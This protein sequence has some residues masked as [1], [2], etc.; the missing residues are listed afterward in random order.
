MKSAKAARAKIVEA[1][2]RAAN[3]ERELCEAIAHASK[4][5]QEFQKQK[6]HANALSRNALC[7]IIRIGEASEWEV[8]IHQKM[9]NACQG[10]A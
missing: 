1:N 10:E 7:S 3:A 8:M 4:M 5:E 2:E 6:D 9:T